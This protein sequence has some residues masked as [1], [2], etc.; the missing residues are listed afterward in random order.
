MH[1]AGLVGHHIVF[2]RR[3]ETVDAETQAFAFFINCLFS[4]FIPTVREEI[5]NAAQ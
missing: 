1:R 2:R 3:I 4:Y 5:G